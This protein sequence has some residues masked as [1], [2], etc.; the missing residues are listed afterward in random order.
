MR[1]VRLVRQSCLHVQPRSVSCIASVYSLMPVSDK[2]R[3]VDN[4]ALPAMDQ[5]ADVH[6]PARV[7]ALW[8]RRSCKLTLY[9]TLY[10]TLY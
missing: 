10:S 5:A 8:L 7:H 2:V 3:A 1:F 4:Q 6:T 9:S